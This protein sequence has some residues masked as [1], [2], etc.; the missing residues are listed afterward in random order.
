MPKSETT[1]VARSQGGPVV[2][3]VAVGDVKYKIDWSAWPRSD[4]YQSVAFAAG[5]RRSEAVI[6]SVGVLRSQ[7]L[8]PVYVGTVRVQHLIWPAVEVLDPAAA[9]EY[10][11]N[12]ARLWWHVIANPASAA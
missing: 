3:P 5:Y 9:E 8:A 6:V 10:L 11:V 12:A 7:P 4:L 1:T 2:D